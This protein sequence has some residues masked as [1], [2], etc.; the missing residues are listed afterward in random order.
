MTER[1][2]DRALVFLMSGF[3]KYSLKPAWLGI[4]GVLS[5]LK[6]FPGVY[7]L[8]KEVPMMWQRQPAFS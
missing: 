7:A 4:I 1:K 2:C 8:E 6:Q 5:L 3:Q